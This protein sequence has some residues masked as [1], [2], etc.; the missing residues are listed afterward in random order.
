MVLQPC[1]EPDFRS[2][3]MVGGSL[4]GGLMSA[5]QSKSKK[6]D[7]ANLLSST[8]VSSEDEKPIY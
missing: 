6:E 4:G 2:P 7:K 5:L 1:F 8:D 3:K